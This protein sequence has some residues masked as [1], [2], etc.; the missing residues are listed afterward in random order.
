MRLAV[1]WDFLESFLKTACNP[2]PWSKIILLFYP[3]VQYVPIAS[4][5]KPIKA[6]FMAAQTGVSRT[7][8]KKGPPASLWARF[9]EGP[10]LD[11]SVSG[12]LGTSCTLQNSVVQQKDSNP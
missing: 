6:S 2:K 10:L 1:T 4:V 8:F 3:M 12:A 7:Q 11:Q 9:T 5:S